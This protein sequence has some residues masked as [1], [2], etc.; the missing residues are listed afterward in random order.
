MLVDLTLKGFHEVL[1]SDSPAPG[2]GSVAAL[3][4]NLGAGLISMV[5]R[6]TIGKKGYESSEEIAK[7]TLVK[8]D[9][10]GSKLLE[11]VDADTEAFNGVMAAFKM[12]KS[13][14]EEKATRSAAIQSGYKEAIQS[15]LSIAEACLATLELADVMV[16]K[17]NAN[18]LSDIGVGAD[19]AFSGLEGA[20]MNVE[21]N[22]PS[23]K[24]GAFV[25]E[26]S[27]RVDEMTLRGK[28]LREK[29]HSYVKKALRG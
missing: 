9:S 20:I 23:V 28:D 8:C 12:P 17:G 24:D 10:L 7:A 14:D 18:A 11:Y 2:G 19:M 3:S 26:M 5:C 25:K 4:G 27:D 16:D 6:L 1:A 21:I 13:T 15:P 29:I 22:L